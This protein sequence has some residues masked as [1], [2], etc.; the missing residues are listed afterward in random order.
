[1]EILSEETVIFPLPSP[2][3]KDFDDV[4]SHFFQGW[5]LFFINQGIS[6][7]LRFDSSWLFVLL[8]FFLLCSLSSTWS[9]VEQK[10][11]VSFP[12]GLRQHTMCI[13]LFNINASPNSNMT[14]M[15][16]VCLTQ[17]SKCS[18]NDL[19]LIIHQLNI[20]GYI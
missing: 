8:C 3:Q 9:R 2:K 6:V 14:P 4:H 13:I 15:Q 17:Q 18:M 12:S 7:S 11:E 16:I 10:M 20:L 19:S 1:M 5:N